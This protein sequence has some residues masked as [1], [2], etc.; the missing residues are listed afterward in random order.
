MSPTADEPLITNDAVVL[1][2]LLVILFTVFGSSKSK[3][4]YFRSV[5]RFVPA[6]LLC[7]FF[8]ALL[9]SFGVVSDE[10]SKLYFVA[11]RYLL[12]AC[13]ILLTLSIDLRQVVRLGPKALIMF[14]T[15]T[16][17]IVIGGPAA[18]WLTA[19]FAPDAVVGGGQGAEATWRGLSTV[20]G[21]WIGGGANQMAMKEVFEVGDKVF[22]AMIAVDVLVANAWMA[23][24][25][26][27]AG[28]APE[29]DK[30]R[31]ADTSAI[32]AVQRQVEQ[33]RAKVARIPELADLVALLAV[34]FGGAA[35][36]HLVADSVAPWIA[37]HAP[38][39]KQLS[40]TGKFFWLVVVA[41][42][43]G[44]G[45]SFTRARALEGVGASTVGSAFLYLL[46]ATIGMKMDLSALLNAPMMFV[47][48]L[49]W[50]CIHALLLLIVAKVIRAPLFFLAV[51]S[52][53][54]VGGAASAPIVASAFHPSLA[55]VGVLLAVVGYALGT[56]AAWVC[57][58]LLRLVSP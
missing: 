6:P 23:V 50:I 20:A 55:S 1:G 51:G 46:I 42:T 38:G 11:S 35:L 36:A 28:R 3:N 54:N 25:L 34:A 7:Y 21:S 13:L 30:R 40:L 41:T 39:L 16:F 27:L 44:L 10:H 22:T 15:G 37:L 52:Q 32:T 9:A 17:G 14:F 4:R 26:W 45:A 19:S 56:Y 43:F 18:L 47:I 57:G 12:P 29:I 24:L 48:G 8:P 5:Y 31:G 49:I 33:F 53:A 2:L 58:Q